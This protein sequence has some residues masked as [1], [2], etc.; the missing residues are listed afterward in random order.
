MRTQVLA[1]TVAASLA[2]VASPVLGANRRSFSFGGPSSIHAAALSADIR[3]SDAL[4]YNPAGLGGLTSAS[5]DLSLTGFVF[6]SVSVEDGFGALFPG[7]E[8]R[9]DLG[10]V[11]ILPNP[12]A[13]VFVRQLDERLSFAF[14]VFVVDASDNRFDARVRE[15]AL[16]L[17]GE[18]FEGVAGFSGQLL[19]TAYDIGG[20]IGWQLRPG[21]RMGAG[22]FAIYDRSVSTTYEF[23][24]LTTADGFSDTVLFASSEDLRAT[25][26]RGTWG[27]QWVPSP[28]L[29]VGVQV[30]SPTVGLYE[31]GEVLP[32]SSQPVEAGGQDL[33]AEAE[34]VSDF[35]A[36]LLETGAAEAMLAWRRGAWTLGA[37]VEVGLPAERPDGSSNDAFVNGRVGVTVELDEGWV[38]GAGAFTDVAPVR[39]LERP[40]DE[41]VD[42]FGLTT[43]ALW[44][45]YLDEAQRVALTTTLGLG[46]HLGVGKTGALVIDAVD[47]DLVQSTRPASTTRHELL[48]NVG[49]GIRY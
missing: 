13:L 46:Y 25:G 34:A 33:V 29:T 21:L 36:F 1:A 14:G 9:A 17:D 16:V 45:T 23:T 2:L 7:R 38:L 27:L 15:E 40:L 6:R 8:R 41:R 30:R 3:A 44:T 10:F 32:L 39:T 37:T 47:L 43:G 22:L 20:G 18:T 28:G 5:V 35:G 12:S 26:L 49:S 4:Y 42:F 31:W 48:L 19:S 11:E 24:S